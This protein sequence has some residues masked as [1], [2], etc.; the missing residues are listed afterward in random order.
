MFSHENSFRKST[1]GKPQRREIRYRRFEITLHLFSSVWEATKEPSSIQLLWVMRPSRGGR[2]SL[3]GRQAFLQRQPASHEAGVQLC[4]VRRSRYQPPTFD[5]RVMQLPVG[6]NYFESKFSKTYLLFP[7]CGLN[8]IIRNGYAL[9]PANFV[10]WASGDVISW[11]IGIRSACNL[12]FK[13][14]LKKDKRGMIFPQF[15][16]VG[17]GGFFGVSDFATMNR[18]ARQ[19]YAPFITR[20]RFIASISVPNFAP[21]KM[22]SIAVLAQHARFIAFDEHHLMF[23]SHTHTL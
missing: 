8:K 19:L 7:F 11:I 15:V 4:R 22:S 10:K 18:F 14:L 21:D 5:T 2:L 16:D 6:L 13:K 1:R 17:F 9:R 23:Y 20:V 12:F 3:D